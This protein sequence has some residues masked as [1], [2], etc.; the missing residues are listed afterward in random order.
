[1]YC[2]H[3]TATLCQ[4]KQLTSNHQ[5]W[6]TR[7]WHLSW[8]RRGGN[9]IARPWAGFV[10]C[11][12]FL[13][14]ALPFSAFVG[15][16]LPDTGQADC[17][18]NLRSILQLRKVVSPAANWLHHAWLLLFL[19]YHL[20]NNYTSLTNSLY[21]FICYIVAY[22]KRNVYSFW[23]IIKKTETIKHEWQMSSA[24]LDCY[25]MHAALCLM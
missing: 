13:W 17:H 22:I 9:P 1:M 2:A 4:Q 10:V 23:K 5:P 24:I 21:L 8:R 12:T 11:W 14:S 7:E 25:A 19:V 3:Y 15:P 16:D 20:F 6:H 18:W